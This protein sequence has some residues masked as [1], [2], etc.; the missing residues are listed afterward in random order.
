MALDA[1][2]RK[3]Y[4]AQ[5][6]L[7][8]TNPQRSGATAE[9]TGRMTEAVNDVLADFEIYAGTAYDDSPATNP[10]QYTLHINIGVQGVIAKLRLRQDQAGRK[11][12][13]EHEKW[14]DALRAFARVAAR[15][16]IL[17][18]T[19]AREGEEDPVFESNRFRYYIPNSPRQ[20]EPDRELRLE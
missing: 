9:D 18:Q 16:R 5:R 15:D 7:T 19:R 6:I 14:R 12:E 20:T 1:E 11:E 10:D 8:L 13:R 2:V 17:P 4:S 3:R